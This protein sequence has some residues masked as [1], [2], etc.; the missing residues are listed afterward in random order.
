MHIDGYD[1]TLDAATKFYNS[2]RI[3]G[4]FHHPTDRLKKIKNSSTERSRCRTTFD[5]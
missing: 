4:W 5:R 1:I 3:F 2:L